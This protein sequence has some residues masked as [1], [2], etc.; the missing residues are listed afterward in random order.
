MFAVLTI[1]L[2][3]LRRKK[4]RTLMTVCGTAIG[5]SL[6]VVLMT[7]AHGV[8]Y[9]LHHLIDSYGIEIAVQ[10]G[11][12]PNPI[13][14][15]IPMADIERL[16]TVEGVDSASGI[17]IG[18][19]RLAWNHYFVILGIDAFDPVLK[20]FPLLKGR[21]FSNRG[22]KEVMIGSLLA[23][24]RSL[25]VGD[26]LHLERQGDFFISGIFNAGSPVFD[27][28]AFMNIAAAQKV[29]QRGQDVNLLLV[30]LKTGYRAKALIERLSNRFPHLDIN[31]GF[32]F[33][34]QIRV[35]RTINGFAEIVAMIS[36]IACCITVTNI[37]L[38]A[39]SER[40]KEI[41]ILMTIGW[42]RWRIVQIILAESMSICIVGSLL[43]NLLGTFTLWGINNSRMLGIGWVPVFP[44]FDIFG[45]SIIIGVIM[46]CISSLYPAVVA[47]RLLP[48]DALRFVT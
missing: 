31:K 44:S 28:A 8:T 13:S 40:T 9:Q 26:Y 24:K 41:G 34:S 2:K 35:F 25:A 47:S 30:R 16:A 6:F 12:A 19:K 15:R 3:N 17:V 20:R 43:G 37:L 46:A 10:A 4:L 32:D 39:I 22:G 36:L 23:A 29:L 33:I 14:S 18:S 11:G 5:L 48:A 7:T 27:G 1:A 45:L 42:S 38:I 21:I